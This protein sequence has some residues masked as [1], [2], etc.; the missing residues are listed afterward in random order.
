MLAESLFLRLER[1]HR[2]GF[3]GRT[4]LECVTALWR[5]RIAVKAIPPNGNTASRD[6]GVEPENTP[7]S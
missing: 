1:G 2:E 6:D 5:D 3:S 7:T 4:P